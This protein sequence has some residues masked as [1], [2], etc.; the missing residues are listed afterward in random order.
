[1]AHVVKN[2]RIELM[3]THPGL[4]DPPEGR[5]DAADGYPTCGDGWRDL[6]VQAFGFISPEAT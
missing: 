4:F 5:P 3:E 2:W 6:P 1:M